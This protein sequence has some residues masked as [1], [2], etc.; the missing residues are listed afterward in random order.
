MIYGDTGRFP[1]YIQATIRSVKYWLRL[2]KMENRRYPRKVYQMMLGSSNYT[3]A[4]KIRDVLFDYDLHYVW[5]EQSVQEEKSFL[6][7]LRDRMILRYKESWYNKLHRSERCALYRIFKNEHD[8]ESYL[9]DLDKSIFRDLYARFRFGVS[10]LYT[11]RYRYMNNENNSNV[12]PSCNEADEDEYHFLFLCP[13]Y[14]DIRMKYLEFCFG[15]G[16]Q[17]CMCLCFSSNDKE[18]IRQVS[19]YVFHALKRRSL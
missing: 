1:M 6:K 3:W 18:R 11:H 13:A 8:I 4:G 16:V 7:E 2:L 12:C 19:S 5:A 10:E 14:E 15:L 17:E 9:F